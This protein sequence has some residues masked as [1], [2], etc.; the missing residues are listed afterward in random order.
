MGQK[1]EIGSQRPSQVRFERGGGGF[2]VSVEQGVVDLPMFGE[3]LQ[4]LR[5]ALMRHERRM[6]HDDDQL[7]ARDR[8][9]QC[10]VG[11][12]RK[13]VVMKIALDPLEFA[14]LD[15]TGA[16]AAHSVAAAEEFALAEKRKRLT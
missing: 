1:L 3:H 15:L 11:A 14:G 2:R 9:E 16:G 12:M 6:N 10:G 5:G 13:S 7:A 8:L 4:E